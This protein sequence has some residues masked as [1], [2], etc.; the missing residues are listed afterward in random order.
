M[1]DWVGYVIYGCV[2]VAIIVYNIYRSEKKR[3]ERFLKRLEE[4]WGNFSQ[5]EY[6]H[7]EYQ[8]ISYYAA[9]KEE[10]WMVDDIT[11]NDLDMDRIFK[12]MNTTQ[13]SIGSEVLYDMLRRPVFSQGILTERE[14]LFCFMKEH[15]R[16]RI[17]MQEIFSKIG[18]TREYAIADYISM[19]AQAEKT[20]NWIHYGAAL[21]SVFAILSLFIDPVVG[22][23][24]LSVAFGVSAYTYYREKAQVEPYL[25]SVAYMLRMMNAAQLLCKE[26][27][28]GLEEY[29]EK[30][31]EQ[32]KKLASFQKN[33]GLVMSMKNSGSPLDVVMD[34]IRMFFHVDL[35]KFN[36]MISVLQN[37][38]EEC[39][40]MMAVI[41]L[42]EAS[43]AVASFREA[44][45]Y[46]CL[47][48]LKEEREASV[49]LEGVYHPMIKTPVAN[50]ITAE[51]GVLIT[52][53]NAS[54]KSTFL[55]TVAING[56]LSQTIHTSVAKKYEAP[57][58]RIYSSMA[59]RDNLEGSESY[60]IVE[61]KALHRI[62]QAIEEEQVPVLAFVDEVLRGTNTVER[63]A[64]SAHILQHL[65]KSHVLTFAA[66]HD[67]ELT[68]LLEQAYD[69]YHFTEEVKQ[70]DIFF[71]Y[72]LFQ[73]RAQ[74]RNAIK[75]LGVM[76]Y[77]KEVVEGA[78]NC[79]NRFLE[80]GIWQ[81]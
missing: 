19:L 9:Q 22:I 40:E 51:R 54:G 57:F 42:L 11:W 27:L 25:M 70:G 58:F 76:G 1:G 39:R 4:Q 67:I 79:A 31:R 26:K 45:D 17:R 3:K 18:K 8:C 69:N 47:P 81:L 80:Q 33:A 10:G 52:G 37:N 50:S 24:I 75:L 49:S 59:L 63:I 30:L 65:N 62:M 34:Y 6:A 48:V 61:I 66:T 73:G 74:S 72:K 13:S 60:Y 35:I 29:Q 46:Y 64:A 23:M 55:K 32:N 77:E 28:V 2:G 38:L 44:L 16:E 78:E 71:S 20:R 21:L 41:G 53:S 36:H 7:E 14:R 12:A 15:P 68:Y 43:I 5:R 56:I